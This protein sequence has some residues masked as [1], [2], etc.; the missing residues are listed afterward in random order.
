MAQHE[1][2]LSEQ[3]KL[4][5]ANAKA[6]QVGVI[7]NDMPQHEQQKIAKDSSP[8][9]G[10]TNLGRMDRNGA[11]NLDAVLGPSKFAHKR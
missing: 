8:L 4:T 6:S 9:R 3:R 1:S 10:Y 11:I 7:S 2:K 5:S